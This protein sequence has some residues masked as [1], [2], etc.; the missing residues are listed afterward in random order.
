MGIEVVQ[1]IYQNI[2]SL[3]FLTRIQHCKMKTAIS[4]QS[5]EYVNK[6]SISSSGVQFNQQ[7]MSAFLIV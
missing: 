7:L 3:S 4:V 6:I 5:K 2:L 1:G